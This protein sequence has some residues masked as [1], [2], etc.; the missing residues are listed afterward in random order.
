MATA[1][2]AAVDARRSLRA[3]AHRPHL[4]VTCQPNLQYCLDSAAGDELHV[5][6]PMCRD[7]RDDTTLSPNLVVSYSQEVTPHQERFY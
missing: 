1:A 3:E 5:D 6:A 2:A 4:P 7:L